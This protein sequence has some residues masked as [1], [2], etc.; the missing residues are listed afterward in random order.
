MQIFQHR[1][2]PGNIREL[3]NLIKRYVILGLE[4]TASSDFP[5][6][7]YAQPNV[8]TSP[9]GSISLKNVTR[10]AVQELERRII[11]RALET[12]KWNRKRV[13]RSLSISYR[14]LL[15]KMRQAGISPKS[16]RSRPDTPAAS[17]PPAD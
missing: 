15:Y 5:R 16:T 9:D 3:E 10:Q 13:A 2:W 6:P 11:L 1:Q 12:N 7:G 17:P 4:E 14:A 8:D